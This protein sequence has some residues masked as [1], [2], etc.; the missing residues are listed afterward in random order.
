MGGAIFIRQGTLILNNATFIGNTATGG[1]GNNPGQGKGGAIFAM[2]SLSNTNGNNQGMP[3]ALPTVISLGATFTDNT[4][5][6]QTGTPATTTPANGIGNSQDNNDV[7]GTILSNPPINGTPGADNLTGTP[8]LD[9]INGL[10]G[11]DTLNGL[12]SNDTLDG[13][14]DNDRLDGGLGARPTYR[15]IG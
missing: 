6:N 15:R 1:T 3:T 11:N 9:T 4:A 12:A 13:G 2:Q 14:D 5:A 8:N 7:Y 10:A